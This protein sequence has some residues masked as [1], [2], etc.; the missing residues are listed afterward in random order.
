MTSINA[1]RFNST[2]GAMVFDEVRGWNSED[3]LIVSAQKMK[4]VIEDDIISHTGLVAGYGNTGTSSIGDELRFTIKKRVSQRWQQ[5][6]EK[7]GKK[8][9][10]LMT[11]EELAH[12]TY[13]TICETKHKHTDELL[14]GRYGFSTDAFIQGFYN[15]NGDKYDI[16]DKDV[17]QAAENAITWK[18]MHS[19]A[20]PLFGNAGIIVGYEPEEGFRIFHMSMMQQ[21]CVPVQEVFAADG[22]G[23]DQCE[24]V[25]SD[26]AAYKSI[27]ERRGEVLPAEGLFHALKA[28]VT[29]SRRNIGVG[30][31]SNIVIFDGKKPGLE[32]MKLILDD[33]ARLA[34]EIVKAEHGDF[35]SSE[36]AI[37]L[38]D[39]LCFQYKS[40]AT[41]NKQLF[42]LA[43]KSHELSRYLRGYGYKE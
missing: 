11:I 39:A 41:T 15:H 8:P 3:M 32:K 10:R 7:N 26:F 34:S 35:I 38:I 42:K 21:F 2:S 43:K 6:I 30:G 16:K 18:E 27:P 24:L 31:Y 9:N 37:E 23:R 1:I 28:I 12:L 36:Q 17:I 25:L 20:R 14:R 19:S 5:E 33:R 29:A 40:W 22:S 13:R 4:P